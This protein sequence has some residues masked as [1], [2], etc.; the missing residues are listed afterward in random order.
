MRPLPPPGLLSRGPIVTIVAL[1]A[2]W[3]VPSG[4]QAAP[5]VRR[6]A[7]TGVQSA[8]GSNAV[9]A[10][11]LAPGLYRDTFAKAGPS[12]QDGTAKYYRIRLH[13]GDTPYLSVTEAS[14]GRPPAAAEESLRVEAAL[15]P[16]D[17]SVAG[18][19]TT[20]SGTGAGTG[21]DL[22]SAT[23]VLSPGRVGGPDWAD[24]PTDAVYA[25]H[26]TR[27]GSAYAGTALPME[28]AV[29]LEP[30][31]TQ[32]GTPAVGESAKNVRARVGGPVRTVVGGTGF[33]NAPTLPDGRYRDSFTSGE[34]RYYRVHLEWGQRLAWTLTADQLPQIPDYQGT[35]GSV[36][37]ANPVRD[38]LDQP[39]DAQDGGTDL[40]ASTGSIYGSTLVPVQWANRS[41]DDDDV[42]PYSIAGDY[43]L[44]VSTAFPDSTGRT[45]TIPYVLTV[46]AVGAATQGPSYVVR[47]T[48]TP[49][50]DGDPGGT[51]VV[52][53]SAIGAV[54]IVGVVSWLL[55]LR[56][57]QRSTHT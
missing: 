8:G 28:I 41:S 29:R 52:L 13:R 47:G 53:S 51:R 43:Y 56:R 37:L 1:L 57:R 20:A 7:A 33:G 17:R 22:D 4:A 44:V 25:L 18:C 40:G 46:Q 55:V 16:V 23:A 26:V 34:R 30:A 42:V 49:H 21:D 2:V 36:V 6:Y 48:A 45:N 35:T 11:D 12:Y 19:E 50:A 10:P 14:P 9:A 24:C 5:A 32:G 27:S 3:V 39:S 38:V 15:A 54:V 31:G